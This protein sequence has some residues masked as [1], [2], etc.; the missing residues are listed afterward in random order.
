MWV[1]LLLLTTM[2][3]VPI[4]LF[5]YVNRFDDLANINSF[6]K[7]LLVP[8]LCQ[9]LSRLVTISSCLLNQSY[10]HAFLYFLTDFISSLCSAYYIVS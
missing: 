8:I 1:L 4:R 6:D 7:Q 10:H 5:V 3:S 9:A 2:E